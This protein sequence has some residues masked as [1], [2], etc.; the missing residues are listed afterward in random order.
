[1]T[2]RLFLLPLLFTLLLA[3]LGR[4][5]DEDLLLLL[6]STG[7]FSLLY[8]RAGG[9]A[10]DLLRGQV[11]QVYDAFAELLQLRLSR[12]GLLLS[13]GLR[14]L[15]ALLALS[16]LLLDLAYAASF[17]FGTP[18]TLPLPSLLL[19]R[20]FLRQLGSGL[21]T[22]GELHGFASASLFRPIQ[23]SIAANL[24]LRVPFDRP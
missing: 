12:L 19:R 8:L 24:R 7:F 20:S 9:V 14:L 6:A 4:F 21:G 3:P 15:A 13:F 5:L 18:P 11:E 22:E 1:M 10:G 23:S 17:R 16:P 2:V